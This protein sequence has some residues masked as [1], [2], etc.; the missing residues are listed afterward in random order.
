MNTSATFVV[1]QRGPVTLICYNV[2]DVKL[3]RN[4]VFS[5]RHHVDQALVGWSLRQEEGFDENN[6]DDDPIVAPDS[7]GINEQ[8][9]FLVD[10]F[11]PKYLC[12]TGTQQLFIR[13][14]LDHVC[15][16]TAFRSYSK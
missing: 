2:I 12:H 5:R 16:R 9:H 11:S 1:E 10:D 13:R 6:E 4:H 8:D 7:E 15:L 3:E 14:P